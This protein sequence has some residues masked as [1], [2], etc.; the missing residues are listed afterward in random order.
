M[1]AVPNQAT[2]IRAA[3]FIVL[4]ELLFASMG[5]AIRQVAETA[6]TEQVVFFRNL[7]GLSLLLPWLMRHRATGR[8][9]R[10]RTP[11]RG[12]S[13]DRPSGGRQVSTVC[14]VPRRATCPG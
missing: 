3:T 11:P 12:S 5:V 8:G 14:A 2:L 13:T 6:S 4:A 10:S 9:L 1:N 7:F